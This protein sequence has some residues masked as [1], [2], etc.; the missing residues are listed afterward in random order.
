[1]INLF[2]KITLSFVII[3][4]ITGLASAETTISAEGQYIF[5]T[6]G[7]YL[8]GILVAFM[9]AGFCM[10]ECG[11]VTTKSVSTIAAKNI[12][13]F[14]IASIV[15]FLC[16][17]N[18]AYGIPEGGYIG[19]F[20]IWSD[21]S[22]IG[23][24]YSDYSDWFY[25]AMF[26][27]ATVSIVSGAVAE[28]IKIWPFFIFSAIMAAFIYPI[29]MGWQWGGGWLATAGFSDFAGSTLVHACG[30][31]A[32]LA[33]VMVLGARAG[34]FGKKGETKSLVPFAASSIPLVTL[35]TFLLWFGWF[36]FNGFSQLAVGT[37]DDVTAISKI[38]VNTHLAGAAGTVTAA[39]VTRWIGG[40][41]DIIM[42]LNGALAGLVAIT[43]EPLNPSPILAMV[44]GSIG[45]IIMYFGTKFLESKHLD[46]VVGA[47]PVHMFAGIF[48]TLVVPIS[49]PDT[50]FGTQL[51]GVVS[52]CVFSFVLSYILFRVL[53]ASIGLRI[54]A[55]A[56]KLG[57]DV[58]EVGVKAYAIRD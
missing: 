37:F 58:A 51:M 41:T 40:K 55:Q 9:A 20:K 33:G 29:S 49:N 50:T 14:A 15:F 28:R 36:G 48:G 42:M 5:N 13:K 54:S 26:V 57:T 16:G 17:Y 31:A 53:K 27:C 52:V 2:K 24:G 11:L 12:G 23:T 32:A 19:S 18:L 35:G 8:G 4:S 38:A 34:R 7:F 39:L 46:D 45:A 30:G 44:I 43:A 1:M 10:L 6:L 3:F 22:E 21:A 47:I 25:Q 56:E